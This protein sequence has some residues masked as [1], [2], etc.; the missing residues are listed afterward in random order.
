MEINNN[1]NRSEWSSL[2]DVICEQPIRWQNGRTNQRG[3][4]GE[5]EPQ[6]P[7]HHEHSCQHLRLQGAVCQ[8]V[9]IPAR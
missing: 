9:Q 5:S 8:R 4:R 1:N 2:T 6:E 3:A 7:G